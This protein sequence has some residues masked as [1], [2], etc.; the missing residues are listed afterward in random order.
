MGSGLGVWDPGKTDRQ[1]DRVTGMTP[2]FYPR[3][4]RRHDFLEAAMAGGTEV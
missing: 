3:S 4:D 2:T 1:P